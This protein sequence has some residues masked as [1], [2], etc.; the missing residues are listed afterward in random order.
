MYIKDIILAWLT[1][2]MELDWETQALCSVYLVIRNRATYLPQKWL[3]VISHY[4]ISCCG[5]IQLCVADTVSL[6]TEPGE[7]A[8][9]HSLQEGVYLAS[10]GM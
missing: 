4:V 2:P 10:K 6:G 9:T 3:L 8:R 7:G 1:R 5:K